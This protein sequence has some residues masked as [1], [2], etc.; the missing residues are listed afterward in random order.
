VE[1]I[2]LRPGVLEWRNV[3]GEIVALDL[4]S[5][6]YL[7]VN[8][9]GAALWTMLVTGSDRSALTTRLVE[10]YALPPEQAAADVDS[11]LGELADQDLLVRETNGPASAHE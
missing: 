4:R 1:T 5:Q 2:R 6:L 8:R 11:F 3:E 10:T 9:T 7:S